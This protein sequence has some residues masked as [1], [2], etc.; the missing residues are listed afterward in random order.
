MGG[1]IRS[2]AARKPS[3]TQ[4]GRLLLWG[5]GLGR[6]TV[7]AE[8]WKDSSLL[9]SGGA[10]SPRKGCA[11]DSQEDGALKADVRQCPVDKHHFRV[12]DFRT[13]LQQA[14]H[15]AAVQVWEGG[16]RALVM[17]YIYIVLRAPEIAAT[18]GSVMHLV[19]CCLY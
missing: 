19:Q 3:T 15:S 13:E 14:E 10:S 4:A 11:R 8:D 17:D 18:V 16:S 12:V 2:T 6:G 5:K 7:P 9:G 1:N